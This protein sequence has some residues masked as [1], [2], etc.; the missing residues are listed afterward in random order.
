MKDF[1]FFFL[2]GLVIFALMGL[3]AVILA[4]IYTEGL[5]HPVYTILGVVLL[6]AYPMGKAM[7]DPNF[8]TRPSSRGGRR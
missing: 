6:L 7:S 5:V 4:V 1:L 3:M 8:N 2:G